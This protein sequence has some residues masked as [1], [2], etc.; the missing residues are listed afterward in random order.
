[1]QERRK[2]EEREMDANVG[3]KDRSVFE[4]VDQRCA[5]GKGFGHNAEEESIVC[6]E[7]GPWIVFPFVLF[8]CF[9][10]RES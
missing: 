10:G 9:G 5:F 1:M 7:S 2:E 6:V 3:R 4:G 8:L